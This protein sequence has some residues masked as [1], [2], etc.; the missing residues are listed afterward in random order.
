MEKEDI[1]VKIKKLLALSESSNE[2]ESKNALLK[3]QE[4]LIKNKLSMEDIKE[5]ETEKVEVSTEITDITF[6]RA[7][8][9]SR[10]ADVIADN[11]CCYNYILRSGTNRIV[12]MGKK[13]D[14]LVCKIVYSYAIESI[15]STVKRM[16]YHFYKRRISVR[17]LETD[18]A[19]GFIEGLKKSFEEQKSKNQEWGLV[20]IKDSKVVEEYKKITFTKT[21]NFNS[22][23]SGF[24]KAY[25]AGE[26]DGKRFNI[27]DRIAN[28]GEEI[29]ELS[30]TKEYK[31]I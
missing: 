6:T 9:K 24:S 10:L 2:N 16:Q 29:L 1:I 20:I 22:K 14:V 15:K 19:L 5:N 23:Y 31:H 7:K 3:A 30:D 4:L 21:A 28:E 13:E 11:F 12:F 17:G 25:E 27:S 8:W 26:K 18:Y